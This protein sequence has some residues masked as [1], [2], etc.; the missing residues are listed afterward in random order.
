MTK[1][2]ISLPETMHADVDICVDA[3]Q[4]GTAR[5]YIRDFTR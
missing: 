1:V 4:Y 2:N 3:G 5:E